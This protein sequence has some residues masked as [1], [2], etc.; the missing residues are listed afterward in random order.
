M[1][2]ILFLSLTLILSYC[3]GG[4]DGNSVPPFLLYSSVAVGD[5]NGDGKLDIAVAYSY[6]AGPPPHPGY[7][8]VYLQDPTNPGTFLDPAI[9]N[10]GNDPVSISIGDL[11]G[12][13]KLDVFT[14]NAILNADGAGASTVSVLLQDPSKPGQFLAATSYATGKN[15]VCV[16][17]G[18]LNDDGRPDLAVADNDGISV[19]F[20]NPAAPGTFFPRIPVN[21]DGAASSVAIAD[22]NNDGRPDLVVANLASVLVLL[23]DPTKAGTFFAP[24][25]Y[26]AGLQP[27]YA[28]V[29]DLD[30][31]GK[32]D[33]AAANLGSLS[34]ARS[35]SVSVLLQNPTVPGSFLTAVNYKTDLRAQAVA[36]ADLNGDGKADLAVANSGTLGGLCPPNCGTAGASVSVLLQDPAV[37]GQF[38]TAT[39]YPANGGDFITWVATGDMN[40]DGNPDLIIGQAIGVFIRFQYPL[41]SGQFQAETAIPR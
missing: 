11:T 9:Y 35:A 20:Q 24:K 41:H 3:G 38:Q 16:A 1:I 21:V 4:R 6:V 29:G 12:N 39:N 23:Q 5:L 8:A 10:V 22:L 26:G 7:V 37:P 31:D 36:I 28:T 19:L 2:P 33:I 13:G 18:D 34:D 14:A 25:S 32:P 27:V 30:G 15:P 17:S 40:G